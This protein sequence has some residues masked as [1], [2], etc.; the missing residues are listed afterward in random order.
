MSNRE[1]G[2]LARR[3]AEN[4]ARIRGD[5]S[6]NQFCKKIGMSNATLNRIENRSQNVT[7]ATLERI[8]IRL[9]IDPEALLKPNQE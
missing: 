9:R 7:I 1:K 6:Q 3:L 2:F 4:L 8:C 5:M